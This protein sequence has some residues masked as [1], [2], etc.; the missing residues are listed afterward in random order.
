MMT[1]KTRGTKRV[2][3]ARFELGLCKAVPEIVMG[4]VD[5]PR[6]PEGASA[7]PDRHA[8]ALP[9]AAVLEELGVSLESGL[10][11]DEALSRLSRYGANST[12]PQ[13]SRSSWELVLQEPGSG[14]CDLKQ[15]D[16][17]IAEMDTSSIQSWTDESGDADTPS[18]A[19]PLCL[20][21]PMKGRAG[22]IGH[23]SP[24]LWT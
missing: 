11:E 9:A 23:V 13:P 22:V 2:I 3:L 21:F 12:A 19:P 14:P 1:I 24:R 4:K 20:L 16:R 8:H 7:R 18:P 17:H 6:C 5:G 10:D 15:A